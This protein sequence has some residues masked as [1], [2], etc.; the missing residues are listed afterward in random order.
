MTL[1]A[2]K[3]LIVLSFCLFVISSVLFLSCSKKIET[4]SKKVRTYRQDFK[5]DVAWVVSEWNGQPGGYGSAFLVDKDL[6]VFYTNKHVSGLFNNYGKGSHKLFFCGRIYGVEVIKV[7][8]L[9]DAALIRITDLFDSSEFPEPASFSLGKIK[10]GEKIYLE[11]FHPHPYLLILA[12]KVGGYGQM[13]VPIWKD[14]YNLD[15]KDLNKKTEVVF[16]KIPGTVIEVSET[17]EF[18]KSRD[19]IDKA[20]EIVN[21]YVIVKT[22]RDHLFSFGGLS[23]T[24]V[25]NGK[26]ETVGIVTVEKDNYEEEKKDSELKK[27]EPKYVKKVFNLIGFTPIESVAHLKQY[28]QKR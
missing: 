12:N 3:R 24:V 22:E 2:S 17:V 20:R 23:G 11:G 6:G 4:D 1:N 18:E 26:G 21:T 10:K 15:S 14:Y 5:S 27:D 9:R 8:P 19:V 28:L 13:I 25:R 16:E 7:H